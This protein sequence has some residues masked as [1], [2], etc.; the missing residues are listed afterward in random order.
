MVTKLK[1]AVTTA[2]GD[3]S[4]KLNQ[5]Q[6]NY[7]RNQLWPP[8]LTGA[9]LGAAFPNGS[10]Q[11]TAEDFVSRLHSVGLAGLGLGAVHIPVPVQV[12][13][14]EGRLVVVWAARDLPGSGPS[15]VAVFPG[16]LPF[17]FGAPFLP[18]PN[19]QRQS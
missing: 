3:A 15:R 10:E 4:G 19:W 13:T 14:P 11:V 9:Q 8:D 16:V 17:R 12:R 18:A 6:W 7:Y 1:A 2:G 5:D